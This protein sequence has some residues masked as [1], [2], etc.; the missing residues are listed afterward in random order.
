MRLLA[1]DLMTYFRPSIC[2]GRVYLRGEGKPEAE[3]SAYEQVLQKL[4][5]QHEA[6]YLATLGEH[7][8]LS[9]VPM[10]QR[11]PETMKAINSGVSVIYQPAFIAKTHLNGSDVEIVG[12]PDYLIRT[13]TGYSIRDSKLSRRIDEKNHPE[14][15][16]QVQLY[17]WLYQQTT[18][19]VPQSL[20]VHSGTGDVVAIPDDGGN[21]A[22]QLL[23]IIVALRQLAAEPHEPVGWSKCNGC[24]FF[25]R[26]WKAAGA[27]NDVALV[28]DVDQGLARALYGIGVDMPQELLGRFT[29]DQLSEFKRPWGKKE[30]RVGKGAD[31]ILQLAEVAVSKQERV[32][33]TP[34]IPDGTNFVMFDLEGMPPY[35]DESDKIYL[36]GMQ[37]FGATPTKYMAATADFGEDGDRKGWLEFL[38]IS[39]ELFDTYGD[40]RFVHW[41]P[42]ERT[43]IMRYIERYGDPEG[44]AEKVRNSL[45]DLY[46][47]AKDCL[48]L[49]L[50]SFSLKVVEKHIKF[51][52][53]QA[54]YGGDWSMAKF[55]E[56]TEAEDEAQRQQVMDEILLYNSEDLEAMWA[57]FKWI[58]GKRPAALAMCT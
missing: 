53:S 34:N 36:W 45:L 44:I 8:D 47:V 2:E 16:L 38:R 31:R 39:D 26:C 52:R 33:A 42:Y 29:A 54:E 58:R 55:I 43:N 22:L 12:F 51:Q 48:L 32:L 41:A 23:G 18:K 28:M 49:P 11:V 40:I 19:Q 14:I 1:S 24:G 46:T 20:Q 9:A 50:P 15:L 56:A 57:V 3:A 10:V 25:N 35:F 37:V 21:A 17:G 5:R 6:R 13:G 7:A 27:R 4:G 30:Q